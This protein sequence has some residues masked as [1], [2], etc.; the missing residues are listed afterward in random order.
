MANPNVKN[1]L[2]KPIDSLSLDKDDIR[3]LLNILQERANAACEIECG[4]IESLIPAENLEKSIN[5]LRNCSTL[6]ITITGPDGEELY[7]SIDEV[8]ES[9]SFPER[10]ISLYLNSEML[11]R[12]FY[13]YYPRNQFEV[14]I[15]FSK[16]KV[17]D[18]SLMP[19]SR[20][21]NTSIFKV[22]GFDNTWVNGVFNELDNYFKK[23]SS[24]LSSIHK[25]SIYDIIVWV[26]GIPFG[27]WSCFKLS[28]AIYKVFES[29]FLTSASFV[30][31]FFLSLFILRILFHYFRWIYPMI[32]YKSR[33]ELAIVHRGAVII[34]TLGILGNFIYDVISWIVP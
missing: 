3:K 30:Y 33:K 13:N 25:N 28:T 2:Q 14:L 1:R 32:E 6:K 12:A 17:F 24:K 9:I 22:E 8:F 19:S 15:D 16:P 26:V 21:P 29:T 18:F 5:D 27:F 7:G 31:V 4:H 34:I 20:T 23:N 10:V 11:Y